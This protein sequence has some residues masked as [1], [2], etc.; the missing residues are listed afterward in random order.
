MRVGATL[1]V[2]LLGALAGFLL[3]IVL[4]YLVWV[5][6]A[7]DALV[8]VT[9]LFLLWFVLVPGGVAVALVLL[10]RSRKRRARFASPS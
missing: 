4:T 6:G 9:A 1:L 8:F 3:A 5:G 10:Q 2:G 7:K